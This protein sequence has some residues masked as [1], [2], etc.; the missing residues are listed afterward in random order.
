[1]DKKKITILSI[2]VV[3]IIAVIVV[4]AFLAPKGGNSELSKL[5]Q[6]KQKQPQYATEIDKVIKFKKQL[7]SD[8]TRVESY[9]TLGFVWKSLADR[10]N[11]LNH[12]REAL[13]VYEKA[14]EV[15]KRKNTLFLVNAGNMNIYLKNY[16][17][18]ENYYKEGISV[19]PGD[20][21]MYI[22]LLD[23]Y[24]DY[25]NKSKDEMKKVIDEAA[26]VVM[27]GGAINTMRKIYL[28]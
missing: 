16:T 18:T 14:I 9:S 8:P 23:L 2:I 12:Y 6:L 28:K 21:D 13:K 4:F 26:K 27:S 24:K 7:D 25:M 19:A 22:K 20:T 15:T 5:D 1:M 10:T 17:A 3:A 11:D